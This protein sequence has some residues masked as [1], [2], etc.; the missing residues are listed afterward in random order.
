MFQLPTFCWLISIPSSLLSFLLCH[1]QYHSVLCRQHRYLPF[2][3]SPIVWYTSSSHFYSCFS[4]PFRVNILLSHR[5]SLHIP[6]TSTVLCKNNLCFFWS[7]SLPVL[8]VI[9]QQPAPPFFLISGLF[10]KALNSFASE[11][12]SSALVVMATTPASHPGFFFPIGNS[13]HSCKMPTIFENPLNIQPWL[14]ANIYCDFYKSVSAFQFWG[15]SLISEA[16]QWWVF[17]EVST[18]LADYQTPRH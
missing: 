15:S 13:K 16:F 8:W 17:S 5:E 10:F 1:S 9:Y 2:H 11:H 3:W 6:F 18:F 7:N 14:M 4:P 12:I